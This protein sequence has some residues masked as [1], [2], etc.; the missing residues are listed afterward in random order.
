VWGGAKG[1]VMSSAFSRTYA[2]AYDLLYAEKDYASE[3][4]ILEQLT[5]K[6]AS[7]PVHSFLDLG[8]GTGNH[9]IEL[10]QR[11]YEVCGVDRAEEM[12]AKAR[13]K[14]QAV[15][16]KGKISFY[17]DDLCRVDLSRY[18]DVALMMF[19]V[20]GYQKEN[21]DV[22]AALTAARRHL[23]PGGLLL[24]DVWYGPAV[25]AQRPSDRVKRIAIEGGEILRS[26]TGSLDVRHHLCR[27]R[28]DIWHMEKDRIIAKDRED[29]VMRYFF[30]LELELFLESTGFHIQKLSAF[31]DEGDPNESTWN[32]IGVA[33]ALETNT[34]TS[35]ISAREGGTP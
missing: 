3:C 10:A 23:L 12:L 35:C 34:S 17:Q 26:A 2:T 24:F 29:H 25:L 8:C 21:H 11:G 9:A 30:P 33:Q 4:D 18:F 20:L 5:S 22:L 14:A 1:V 27:V 6:Y 15:A 19:A 31:P 13:E 28:Y 7:N 32:V 16:P